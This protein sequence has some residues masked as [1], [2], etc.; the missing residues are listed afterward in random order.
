[1]KKI[2]GL[3]VILITLMPISILVSC[4][5]DN[6][7]PEVF[8]IPDEEPTPDPEPAPDIEPKPEN[9]FVVITS[10]KLNLEPFRVT[11]YGI[12]EGDYNNATVGMQI[13]DTHEFTESRC[14]E[15]KSSGGEFSILINGIID[16]FTYYYRSFAEIE[17]LKLYGEIKSF[18]TEKLT[19]H[20][21]GKQYEM[22]I[23]EGGPFGDFSM[24]QTEL[25]LTS[26]VEIGDIRTQPIKGNYCSKGQFRDY[27]SLFY[28][29]GLPWRLPTASEW[30]IAAKGGVG[31]LNYT[32]SGG[33]TIG[34]VAWYKGN[35]NGP[36]DVALKVS[37]EL[38]FYDMSGNYSELVEVGTE[39][40]INSNDYGSAD[41]FNARWNNIEAFGGN[42]KSSADECK[43]GSSYKVIE[44]EKEKQIDLKT[45]AIRFVYSRDPLYL[46]GY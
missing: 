25:P 35:S 42:W 31:S 43:I 37:N 41:S 6:N 9:Q 30:L 13:S 2:I 18:T 26:I 38:G 21:N 10:D 20:V 32:F 7:E 16:Q 12:F 4:E 36:H 23:V 14:F 28:R 1:M 8:P 34:D 39:H 29:T 17:G 27:Y 22:I 15:T 45:L 40:Y 5:K 3:I 24:M 46:N 44:A 11:L 33:N 19:Y